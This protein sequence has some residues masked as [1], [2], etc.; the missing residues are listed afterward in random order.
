MAQDTIKSSRDAEEELDRDGLLNYGYE[1]SP[2]N[3]A[4][5]YK[6]LEEASDL[7]W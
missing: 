5:L 6:A 2:W 7:C 1:L 3:K 4:V